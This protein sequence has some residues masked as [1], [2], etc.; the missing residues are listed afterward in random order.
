MAPQHA[1]EP[2]IAERLWY[3]PILFALLLVAAIACTREFL[4]LRIEGCEDNAHE[5]EVMYEH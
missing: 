5:A 2:K 1:S 4:Y 3:L